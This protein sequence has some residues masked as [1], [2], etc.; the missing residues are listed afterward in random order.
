MSAIHIDRHDPGSRR[1]GVDFFTRMYC[2]DSILWQP[3]LLVERHLTPEDYASLDFEEY[4]L[5]HVGGISWIEPRIFS[6][7]TISNLFKVHCP[8]RKN[9]ILNFGSD[10]RTGSH[11]R[12][13]SWTSDQTL[14]TY[15][16]PDRSHVVAMDGID[17]MLSAILSILREEAFDAIHRLRMTKTPQWRKMMGIHQKWV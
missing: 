13:L 9:Y 3:V 6:H 1:Y 8:P 10:V 4:G 15:R 5:L 11:C 12:V 2:D 14:C 16:V 7:K 17:S